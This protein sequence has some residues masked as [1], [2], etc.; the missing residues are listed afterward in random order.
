MH[1]VYMPLLVERTDNNPVVLLNLQ[2][3][4]D[5]KRR[6]QGVDLIMLTFTAAPSGAV[7]FSPFFYSLM[8]R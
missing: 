4:W 7:I 6:T 2:H 1:F 8:H 5:K 3:V